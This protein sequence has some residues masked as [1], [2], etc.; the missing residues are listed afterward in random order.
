[1]K[2]PPF[3]SNLHLLADPMSFGNSLIN[4]VYAL[5]L[6]KNVFDNRFGGGENTAFPTGQNCCPYLLGS[7][8]HVIC[9]GTHFLELVSAV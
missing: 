1:M 4:A 2:W 5:R 8:A 7:D 3:S 9:R 6:P